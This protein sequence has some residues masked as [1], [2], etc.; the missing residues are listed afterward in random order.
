MWLLP[1]SLRF[2]LFFCALHTVT[3]CHSLICCSYSPTSITAAQVLGQL[4]IPLLIAPTAYVNGSS[5]CK[6]TCEA[7]WNI[8]AVNTTIWTE[9]MFSWW[10]AWALLPEN[11]RTV[12][13]LLPL[14][15]NDLELTAERCR[16]LYQPHHLTIG[17]REDAMSSGFYGYI[18]QQKT[19]YESCV[20]RYLLWVKL[21]HHCVLQSEI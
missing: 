17:N 3:A 6:R 5:K 20:C 14:G 16:F 9:T 1:R 7:S 4:P 8:L 12:E 18:W 11:F 2:L 19:P 13:H 10:E 15:C 21:R